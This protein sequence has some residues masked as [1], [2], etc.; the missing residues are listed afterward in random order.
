MFSV[1]AENTDHK[2]IE[3]NSGYFIAYPVLF[4]VIINFICL[5]QK[6]QKARGEE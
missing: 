1:A 6:K 3:G 5:C 4:C 2:N